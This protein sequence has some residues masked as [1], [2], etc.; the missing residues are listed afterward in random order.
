MRLALIFFLWSVGMANVSSLVAPERIL[1]DIGSMVADPLKGASNEDQIDVTRHQ[2]RVPG[3]S[4]NEL[5][6]DI[7]G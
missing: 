3:G 2:L 7:I 6:V 5:F 4:F 1:G